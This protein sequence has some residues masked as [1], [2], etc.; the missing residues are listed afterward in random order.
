MPE[1]PS[2]TNEGCS[3]TQVHAYGRQFHK[4]WQQDSTY[5]PFCMSIGGEVGW[6][7]QEI[8]STLCFLQQAFSMSAV[9]DLPLCIWNAKLGLMLTSLGIRRK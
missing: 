5:T 8:E 3:I 6:D 2:T 1:L 9:F 7:S 4:I